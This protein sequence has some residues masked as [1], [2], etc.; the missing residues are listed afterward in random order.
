MAAERGGA[1]GVV[2]GVV[3]VFAEGFAVEDVEFFVGEGFLDHDRIRPQYSTIVKGRLRE[4]YVA[5]VAV[6]A[7]SMIL[8]LELT[9]RRR[10]SLL[11]DH[12]T[13]SSALQ[14]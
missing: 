4:T 3:V 14:S 2:L 1:E 7:V 13:T 6:E 9:I 11:L 10:Y 5:C 8:A 12:Q